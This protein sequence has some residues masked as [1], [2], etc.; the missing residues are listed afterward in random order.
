MSIKRWTT[1]TLLLAGSAL[2]SAPLAAEQKLETAHYVLH[3]SALST[4]D[5]QPEVARKF[6]VRRNSRQALLVINPQRKSSDGPQPVAATG[7]GV[8]RNLIGHRQKLALDPVR[9]GPVHYLLASFEIVDQE[10]ITLELEILPQ[11]ASEAIP[12]KF[13]QQFYVN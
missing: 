1:A 10:M 5:L 12:L 7:S 13:Q 11:G 9:E 2:L 6:G 4:M 3:Y 8:A